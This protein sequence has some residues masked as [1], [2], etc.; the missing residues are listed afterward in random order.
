MM[1]RSVMSALALLF[2]AGSAMVAALAMTLPCKC[3]IQ[4]V[5]SLT[6]VPGACVSGGADDAMAGGEV[7]RGINLEPRRLHDEPQVALRR[8]MTV[9]LDRLLCNVA[10]SLRQ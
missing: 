2:K 5:S 9:G 3:W 4:L 8:D 10:V 6:A 7:S 1:T